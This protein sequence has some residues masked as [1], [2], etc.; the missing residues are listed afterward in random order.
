M[1]VKG[2]DRYD[3]TSKR[4]YVESVDDC[5]VTGDETADVEPE[6]LVPLYLDCEKGL[7]FFYEQEALDLGAV[8]EG[9]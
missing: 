7:Y 5:P 1:R 4:C 3:A 2:Y 6:A 9:R 8:L